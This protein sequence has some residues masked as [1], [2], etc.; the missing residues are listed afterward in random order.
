MVTKNLKRNRFTTFFVP[1]EEGQ[2]KKRTEGFAYSSY[3]FSC[4]ELNFIDMA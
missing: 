1:R 4:Q 2:L 3:L